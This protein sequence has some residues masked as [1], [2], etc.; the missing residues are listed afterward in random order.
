MDYTGMLQLDFCI[1]PM[2]NTSLQLRDYR[3]DYLW[4]PT[5][6][7]LAT[8]NIGGDR[9]DL[10]KWSREERAEHA[11]DKKDPLAEFTDE[12]IE[13]GDFDLP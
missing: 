3:Q 1:P 4:R 8:D 12:Q 11:F 7:A 13:A 10:T 6:L 2:A 9:Y 5:I